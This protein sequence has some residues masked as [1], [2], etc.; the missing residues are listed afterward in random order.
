MDDGIRSIKN[1]EE[2]KS[3][4]HRVKEIGHGAEGKVSLWVD[5][6][7]GTIKVA[8]KEP[9]QNRSILFKAL[10]DEVKNMKIVGEHHDNIVRFLGWD[11]VTNGPSPTLFFEYCELGDTMQYSRVVAKPIDRLPEMTLWKFM[12]DM[13][14]AL[15]H[16]HN[17]LDTPYVH[18]DLKPGNILVGRRQGIDSVT[19]TMLPTFKI[20]DLSRLEAYPV[21][22]LPSG[23]YAYWGTPEYLV[24]VVERTHGAT[25]AFDVFAIGASIQQL[26]LNVLPIQTLE[27]FNEDRKRRGLAVMPAE[28][29]MRNHDQ[30]RNMIP[31]MYRPL[32]AS[33]EEQ[34]AKWD[35][36]RP[37]KPYS[38]VLNDWYTLFMKPAEER[39]TAKTLMKWFVPF[40]EDHIDLLVAARMCDQAGQTVQQLR[41]AKLRRP[42]EAKSNPTGPRRG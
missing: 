16:I 21:P 31:V 20:A 36:Q 9:V 40:A 22:P 4:F 5:N 3:Q 33:E 24:P 12:V 10:L 7:T 8:V 38:D 41:N 42:S 28:K 26:A 17:Q 1:L 37:Q 6:K 23:K 25:P 15:D 18:S 11:G 34:K 30:Y 35:M 39:I 14:K 32:N 13:S 27:R 29:Y 19:A 2:L